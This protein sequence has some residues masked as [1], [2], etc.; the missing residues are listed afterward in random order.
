MNN[1]PHAELVKICTSGFGPLFHSS[2]D[3]YWFALD[4][5]NSCGLLRLA[6]PAYWLNHCVCKTF[7]LNITKTMEQ[8]F[9]LEA[10]G[11]SAS[12]ECRFM[13]SQQ[14]IISD[15]PCSL[16]TWLLKY[17]KK[18]TLIR[19]L[20][21]WANSTIL[22]SAHTVYLCVLCGS[23]NKQPLFPYTTLTDWFL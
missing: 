2:Y 22:R 5:Y 14:P 20:T 7:F 15:V 18:S 10:D 21:F 11:S 4:Q 9:S 12:L 13:V 16:S 19:V 3:V 17:F 1:S 8:R 6:H 23:E